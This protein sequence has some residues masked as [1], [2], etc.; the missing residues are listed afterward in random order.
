M[1]PNQ[2]FA[3]AKLS[4]EI[5]TPVDVSDSPLT[6]VWRR[7]TFQIEMLITIE[8]LTVDIAECQASVERLQLQ[9]HYL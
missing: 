3:S 4:F 5:N 6:F 9:P 7:T 1:C 8:V 2:G